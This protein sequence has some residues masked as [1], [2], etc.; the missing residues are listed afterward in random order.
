MLIKRCTRETAARWHPSIV[1]TTAPTWNQSAGRVLSSGVYRIFPEGDP[2]QNRK[3][4]RWWTYLAPL[5]LSI[6]NVPVL[7]NELCNWLA[8]EGFDDKMYRERQI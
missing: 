7:K 6:Y 3:L 1:S 8:R 2:P 4:R 5:R